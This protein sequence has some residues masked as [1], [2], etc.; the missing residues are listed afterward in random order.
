M[1]LWNYSAQVGNYLTFLFLPDSDCHNDH[2]F[3]MKKDFY[4]TAIGASAGGVDAIKA[5]FKEIPQPCNTA[6]IIVQHLASGQKGFLK[7]ILSKITDISVQEVTKKTK[8]ESDN[9]YIIP[10]NS[11]LYVSDG[12]LSLQKRTKEE[13]VNNAI[14]IFFSSVAEEMEERSIGVILSG[15]GTDG[16][17]GTQKIK[18]RGGV[19][20][21]QSPTT[22]S[23]SNMPYGAIIAD[24]PDFIGTSSELAEKLK[25]Y[26]EAPEIL[27]KKLSASRK[28]E[29][30]ETIQNILNILIHFSGVNFREYKINTILRRID[31][32]IKINHLYSLEEYLRFLESKPDEVRI[33]F[34]DLLIGVTEF[35]RD[36]QVFHALREKIIPEL[37]DKSQEYKTLRIWVTACSTGEEAYTIAMLFEDYIRKNRLPIELKVFATDLSQKAINMAGRGQFTE[38]IESRIPYDLLK[39]YFIKKGEYYEVTKELRKK[40]IFS[41]H[42]LL[43]DPPFIRLD[44]IACRNLFI[45]LKEDVQKKLLYTFNYSLQNNGYLMLGA[46]ETDSELKDIFERVDSKSKIFKN[47]SS[48][49]RLRIDHAHSFEHKADLR[50]DYSAPERSR[51]IIDHEQESYAELLVERYAP[52]CLVVSEHDEVIYTSGNIERYIK[53]P[54]NRSKLNIFE[55]IS[56]NASLA[57]RNGL[58]N[59]REHEKDVLV[60]NVIGFKKNSDET[61]DLRFFQKPNRGAIQRPVIIE[62]SESEDVKERE[63]MVEVQSK[64]LINE[65]ERLE[66]ELYQSRKELQYNSDELEAINEELQSSNEE[67]KSSNEE[68]QT[69]NEELQSTNEELKTVN[70][71]LQNKIDEITVLH[72]DV[73]N[74]FNSTQ[75]ATVFLDRDLKIRKYTPTVQKYFN[76]REGDIGR[77]IFHYTFNFDHPGLKKDLKTVLDTLQPIKREVEEKEGFV[78]LKIL[79][80]KT[81]DMRIEGVIMTFEDISELK[82]ANLKLEET[83]TDLQ[84]RTLELE[85][86]EKYWKSLVENSPDIIARVNEEGK[87]MYVNQSL[88]HHLM[89]SPEKAQGKLLQDSM[90][91]I[92]GDNHNIQKKIE[93]VFKTKKPLNFF[94]DFKFG[95]KIKHLFLTIW[96]EWDIQNNELKSVLVIGRDVSDIREAEAH[97]NA[98]NQR[99]EELNQYMDNFVHAVAHDLRSPMTNLKLI[100][101]LLYDEENEK[102]RNVLIGKFGASVRRIDDVLNGLIEIIDSQIKTGE[103]AVKVNFQEIIRKVQEQFPSDTLDEDNVKLDLKVKQI[104]YIRGYL[105]SIIR[106]LISNSVKYAHGGRELNVLIKT[107]KDA[108]YTILTISDNG[109]GMDIEKVRPDLFKPFKRFSLETEGKGIGLH[110]IKSMVEK[111]GGKIE[112]DSQINKGT[113]FRVFLKEQ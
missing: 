29:E 88:L 38:Q 79:P 12:H 44:F 53:F 17:K 67:M 85:Q 98:K 66:G 16:A 8:I 4:V 58:S 99:L 64:D 6:F 91:T 27:E 75:I 108:N 110:I 57:V 63:E 80:Y 25:G 89:I 94:D 19:V 104:N 106:N 77:P 42:N 65:I 97:I 28:V 113:T 30:H 81:D 37:C 3:S 48:T 90:D 51:S 82:E 95:N 18:E 49:N 47:K 15:M 61:V 46:N 31:K 73:N 41:V 72:D 10:P 20:M 71:E 111:T 45:Y 86:S 87:T 11:F 9:I 107:R 69:T 50:Y 74:L 54:N 52:T 13:K 100:L 23:F 60:K 103:K 36:E 35:F 76:I 22:A 21:V 5:F 40:I 55:M 101:E 14:D 109:I 39:K 84:K 2:Y 1:L 43:S 92:N 68:M 7:D 26:I 83:A 32:R 70:Q 78:N 24:H 93:E 59:A 112:V 96:P 62:F 56:G 34:N 105:Y 102:K 33:L